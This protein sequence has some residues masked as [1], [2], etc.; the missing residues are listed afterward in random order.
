MAKNKLKSFEQLK[1]FENVI[2]PV[3][4]EILN[5]DFHL[6]GKWAESFFKNTNPIVLE[7]G[8][9]KGEYTTGLAELNPDINYI[10]IDI[11]GARIWRGATTVI[12][13]GLKNVAFIR[14]AIDPIQSFFSENEISE[15]WLTFSD[16]QP[17]KP[18]KRLS[19]SLFLNRYLSFLKPGAIIHLKTDSLIL[20][21]YTYC[22]VKENN[23]SIIL[24][25]NNVYSDDY[26]PDAIKNIQTFYEKKFISVG[27]KINYL[28]FI[29]NHHSTVIEPL[30]FG[31]CKVTTE[32][33]SVNL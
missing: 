28:E 11:K 1:S 15:I 20:F 7:L 2:Q 17:N 16:P 12:E 19:S 3:Y 22:L 31:K 29:V 6:K 14:S 33:Q 21:D 4:A 25:S 13:K 5:N 8:C 26:L 30:E 10:G 18:K 23:F 9:G 27:K 32:L 24:K